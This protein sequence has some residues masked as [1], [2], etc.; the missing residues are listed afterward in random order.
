MRAVYN[1]PIAKPILFL[2]LMLIG[3]VAVESGWVSDD[4]YISFRSVDNAVNGHGLRW[5]GSE[6]V[7][8]FTNTLWTLLLIIPYAMTKEIYFTS[9]ITQI[10]L[11]VLAVYILA[12]R[13][14]RSPVHGFVASVILL[15][16]KS[17]MDYSTSGLE[18]PLSHLT[19]AGFY[20]FFFGQLKFH[21][22]MVGL[23]V[24]LSL[25]MLTRIDNLWLVFPAW[26]YFVLS[27]LKHGGPE[28]G[29]G[30]VV[31]AIGIGIAPLVAWEL[32]SILYFG[33]PLPNTAYAKLN[34]QL[35]LHY[36][37][38]QGFHYLENSL[39]IDALTTVTIIGGSAVAFCGGALFR[40]RRFFAVGIGI[41]LHTLYVVRVGGDFMSGR[42]L[43]PTIFVAVVVLAS[44]ELEQ[45]WVAA[46]V[47]LLAVLGV[48]AI[49]HFPSLNA[50]YVKQVRSIK[51]RHGITDMRRSYMHVAGLTHALDGHEMP[52]HKW[53]KRGKDLRR[54]G[55]KVLSAGGTGFTG[56]YAGPD[57]HVLDMYALSDALLAR[58]PYK[59]MKKTSKAKFPRIGHIKR[60]YP[61]GYKVSLKKNKNHIVDSNLA[62][63][64]EKMRLI[65]RGNIWSKERL[66]TIFK[67]NM[68]FYD[69]WLD[70]YVS[71]QAG[72]Q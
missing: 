68:G 35:P 6:R 52:R 24:F 27:A 15:M 42:L 29:V 1:N 72:A 4:A 46:T 57:V 16:S 2:V 71:A 47:T 39:R 53:V 8:G 54:K 58:L 14:A 12:F 70:K 41:L 50:D 64:Y 22:Q 36:Y 60:S 20:Y 19:L 55:T 59:K 10:L 9:I 63:Y 49:S 13:I 31:L 5:N 34:A 67:M 37:L 43:T 26:L 51:D 38:T 45:R 48:S 69:H 62:K 40:D 17:F 7:Q 23:T 3:G 30:K 33:F 66:L 65:T 32:F 25:V 56:Y 28:F 18:N 11:T 44:I 61:K 21:R